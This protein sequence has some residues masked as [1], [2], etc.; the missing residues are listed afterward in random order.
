M[1]MVTGN[2]SGF[3]ADF[4]VS[5]RLH[6]HGQ[7]IYQRQAHHV[8]TKVCGT[9]DKFSVNKNPLLKQRFQIDFISRAYFF[10]STY[11]GPK[12]LPIITPSFVSAESL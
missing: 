9:G 11:R 2:H 8:V 10:I 1:F 12:N 7:R 5:Q 3:G 4:E 6:A